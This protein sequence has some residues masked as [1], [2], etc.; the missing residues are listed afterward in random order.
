MKNNAS[1]GIF[2][3]ITMINRLL[4]LNCW[5]ENSTAMTLQKLLVLIFIP[6]LISCNNKKEQELTERE[7]A[8]LE[9]EQKFADK[10]AE[11]ELLLKMKDSLQLAVQIKD[12]VSKIQTWPDSLKIKWSSKMIC[13]ES[14]CTNYVIGDQRTEIWDFASDS[15]GMY[16]NVLSNN[17]IKRVFRGQYLVNKIVLDSAKESSAKSNIKINVVLD[18]I[19]KNVIKGTQTITGQDN[20]TAKFSVE[21]T[22]SKK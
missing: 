21:L 12:T 15:T 4:S 11:Y 10:E 16:A 3:G 19:K 22:P 20:C 18:D 7:N 5:L 9:R 1:I 8:L 6:L 17:E 13:R 14:N 2:R